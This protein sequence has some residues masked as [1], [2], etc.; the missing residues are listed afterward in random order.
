MM[1]ASLFPLARISS[2]FWMP[3]RAGPAPWALAFCSLSGDPLADVCRAVFQRCASRFVL[4]EEAHR[5]AIGELD[6]PQVERE[7]SLS[8]L[9][10]DQPSQ[11]REMLGFDAPTQHETYALAVLG[12][13][14]SQHW[15]FEGS[16]QKPSP[17]P[18][19]PDAFAL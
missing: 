2:A 1:S 3:A 4:C 5:V 6:L 9:A 10:L 13:L 15:T 14:N 7:H 12:P 18:A 16:K 17:R 11:L 19:L 8:I